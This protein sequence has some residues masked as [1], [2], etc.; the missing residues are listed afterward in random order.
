LG[1]IGDIFDDSKGQSDVAAVTIYWRPMCGYCET[2]KRELDGRGVDYDTVDIWADR[3]Q[4]DVVRN[5]TGG[6][7]IVPTVRIGS[8][9]FVNP[10]A[11]EVEE[12]AAA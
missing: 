7:E 8:R 3:D 10:S 2:L 5:A 1:R 11:D 6:D 4:A 9:F 12:A